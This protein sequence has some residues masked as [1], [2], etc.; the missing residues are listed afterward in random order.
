MRL[1]ASQRRPAPS[2]SEN[3]DRKTVRRHLVWI[4]WG[5]RALKDRRPARA[6]T[7]GS[8][9]HPRPA[10]RSAEPVRPRAKIV[11]A[12]R[13]RRACRLVPANTRLEL[14]PLKPLRTVNRSRESAGRFQASAIDFRL[15]CLVAVPALRLSPG[16]WLSFRECLRRLHLPPRMVLLRNAGGPPYGRNTTLMHPSS[17]SRNFLYAD[18]ASASFTRWV[19]MNDGSISPA[20]IFCRS[21]RV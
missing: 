8:L 16:H 9:S 19:T 3:I 1:K 17:L 18:G 12:P 4:G 10:S 14:S 15:F 11:R 13:R 5:R 7:A 20:S 2:P 21:G 6:A